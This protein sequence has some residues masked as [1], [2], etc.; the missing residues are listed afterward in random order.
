VSHHTA[1]THHASSAH[2]P[3]AHHATVPHH[4]ATFGIAIAF[5]GASPGSTTTQNEYTGGKSENKPF[6]W[7]LLS[8][9]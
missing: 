2:H 1:T 6:H 5:L 9:I 8:S 3:T 7:Y 4:A